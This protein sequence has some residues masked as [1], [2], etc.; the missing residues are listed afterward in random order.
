MI[1]CIFTIDYEIYGNG[2]GAL[3]N[4]VYE[5]AKRLGDIFLKR[6]L[7]FVNFVEVAE[8]QKIEEC[9]ADP[10]IDLVKR[11][12]SEFYKDRFE[13]ALHLHPQWCNAR[14]EQRLWLL[15]SSEYNLCTLPRP[16][17]VQ[18]VERSLNYLRH[19]VDDLSFTPL[20]FRAGNWLFQP[21]DNA[22]G[23]LAENGLRIDSSVFKGGLQHN[24]GLDYRRSLRNGHYWRF[25]CDVNEPDPAGSWIE[26]PVYAEMVPSWKMATSKR[27]AFNNK[28]GA[29]NNQSRTHKWNRLRDFLRFRYPLKFDFCRMT[30]GELTSMM[31]GI[32][33]QDRKEPESFRP[34]V[35]IGHTKD[36]FDFDTVDRFLSYLKARQIVVSTFTDIFPRL[37]KL[38]ST[39]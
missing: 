33:R 4:L 5:P 20:S 27:L 17:I 3:D 22:A 14:Y 21:T 2:H 29:S 13:I 37:E 10:A 24:Y 34:V 25:Q 18:I 11:Q 23:V 36:L 31:D 19:L 26:V 15:D 8:F 12:I 16:R 9:G 28:S 39:R 1:E 32:I 30:L 35:A 7:R 6:G 38:A